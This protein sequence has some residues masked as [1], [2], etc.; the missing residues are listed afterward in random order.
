MTQTDNST[1]YLARHVGHLSGLDSTVP[2]LTVNRWDDLVRMSFPSTDIN[3]RLCGS[4]FQTAIIGAQHIAL[5]EAEVCL[6]GGV[7]AMS[8]SPYT[9]SGL[10]R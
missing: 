7:E 5:G 9:L 1:P 4:G 8:M 2:A 6:T 10:T 3:H